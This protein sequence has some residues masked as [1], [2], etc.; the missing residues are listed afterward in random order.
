MKGMQT[1]NQQDRQTHIQTHADTQDKH[2]DGQ[3]SKQADIQT[4]GR[5]N[6]QQSVSI[7][8]VLGHRLVAG[9]VRESAHLFKEKMQ[10]APGHMVSDGEILLALNLFYSE[11]TGD[12]YRTSLRVLL[13][14]CA[15]KIDN[16]AKAHG[17]CFLR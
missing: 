10:H 7:E 11:F 17:D 12:F 15:H 4:D 16:I 6:G 1:L 3:A 8:Q 2:T 13:E 9:S 14:G 5:T